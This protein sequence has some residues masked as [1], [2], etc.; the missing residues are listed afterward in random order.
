MELT[1]P[2]H[3]R[4]SLTIPINPEFITPITKANLRVEDLVRT[5]NHALSD[6]YMPGSFEQ[7]DPSAPPSPTKEK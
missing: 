1:E 6:N 5:G 7:D 2:Q 3:I 4:T